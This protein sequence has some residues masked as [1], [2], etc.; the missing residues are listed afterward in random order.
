M[1]TD[2]VY[3]A[4]YDANSG[5]EENV[6]YEETHE[7]QEMSAFD[8]LA[9]S[10]DPPEARAPYQDCRIDPTGCNNSVGADGTTPFLKQL[11]YPTI[12]SDIPLVK[13]TEMRL[14]EAEAG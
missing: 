5:R 9:G 2:Y 1:P 11:K 8:A 4:V 6:I 7:R 3:Y 14:I 10:F 12:G 13:G